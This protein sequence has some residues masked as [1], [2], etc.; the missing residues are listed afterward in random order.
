[1]LGLRHDPA[2]NAPRLALTGLHL[3]AAWLFLTRAPQRRAAS[4]REVLRAL[5]SFVFAGLCFRMAGPPHAWPLP[6]VLVF[7]GGAAFTLVSLASLGRSFAVLP[8]VREVVTRGPYRVVRHP[9][10]AGESLLMLGCFLAAPRPAAGLAALAGVAALA[11]RAG[12]E[13]DVLGEDEGYRRYAEAVP[14][15]MLPG[16]W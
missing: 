11:V 12:A 5:P 1:M 16:V 2:W 8:G 7:V 13:E 4:P 3:L 15:R 9:A 10:Y 6:A 14:A